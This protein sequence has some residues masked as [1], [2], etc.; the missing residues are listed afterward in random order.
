MPVFRVDDA[1]VFPGDNCDDRMGG[2]RGCRPGSSGLSYG[3][4]IARGFCPGK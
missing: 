2:R 3:V 4:K 1:H